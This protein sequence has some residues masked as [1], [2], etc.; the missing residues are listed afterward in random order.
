METVDRALLDQWIA[1]WSDIVEFEVCPVITESTV[2]LAEKGIGKGLGALLYFALIRSA[3]E[4]GFRE[5]I[6]V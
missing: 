5:L 3:V 1:S 6:G 2:Y 4:K